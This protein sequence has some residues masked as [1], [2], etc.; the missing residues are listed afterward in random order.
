MRQRLVAGLRL[1]P[2][3]GCWVWVKGKDKEGTRGVIRLNTH[4][5][6]Q[7]HR[8]AAFLWLGLDLEDSKSYACHTCDN[9][10]CCCPRPGHL[11][12]GDMSSNQLDAYARGQQPSRAG[13]A[14]GRSIL[15]ERQ[16]SEI[17]ELYKQ[18][19]WSQRA[20]G[21]A[22]GVSQ[23]RVSKIIRGESWS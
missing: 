6:I 21:E 19:R 2:A 23:V 8:A 20:I 4:K 5:V 3:T 9:P 22:Y 12:V 13:T 15:S 10:L 18:H 7:V 11:Y 1:D 17:R 16:V 14:N